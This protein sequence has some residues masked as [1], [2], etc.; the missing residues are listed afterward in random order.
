M[1]R[2]KAVVTKQKTQ[3]AVKKKKTPNSKII[4]EMTPR[5]Y[6]PE[7]KAVDAANSL[8]MTNAASG[9]INLLNGLI[10]GPDRHNRIGRRVRMTGIHVHIQVEEQNS[11]TRPQDVYTIGIV[12]DKEPTSTLPTLS[13]LFMN[14]TFN[15]I[16]TSNAIAHNN[17]NNST[18]FQWLHKHH[19]TQNATNAQGTSVGLMIE[20]PLNKMYHEVHIKCDLGVQFNS[21][22]SGALAD[23]EK[24]ALFIIGYALNSSSGATGAALLRYS[25]RVRFIDN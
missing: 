3:I 5:D 10:K 13:D 24:G 4:R 21:G 12:Y 20:T 7:V 6:A 19:I 2:Q 17:L 25:S 23:M 1:P 16:E 22:D 8:F 9:N 15:N 18:R 11:A 14:T